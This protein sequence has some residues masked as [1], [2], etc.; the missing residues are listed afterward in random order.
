ASGMLSKEQINF[1]FRPGEMQTREK[2]I[3]E[4]E[5]ELFAP[6][7]HSHG[8][9]LLAT[10]HEMG[11]NRD[12]VLR[13]IEA[14]KFDELHAMYL[15]MGER[16]SEMECGDSLSAQSLSVTSSTTNMPGLSGG[17]ASS[18]TASVSSES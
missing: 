1:A 11:Y 12:G 8:R 7:V 15:L 13:S 6:V 17:G 5:R 9:I 14:D 4:I 3:K 18:V 10:L 16:K 2:M